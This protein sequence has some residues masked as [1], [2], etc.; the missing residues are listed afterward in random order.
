[1]PMS[2]IS[3]LWTFATRLFYEEKTTTTTKQEQS[4]KIEP[5]SKINSEIMKKLDGSGS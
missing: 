5:K 4:Q 3:R 2:G 1:M